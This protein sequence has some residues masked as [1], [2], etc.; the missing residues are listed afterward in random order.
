MQGTNSNIL[1]L[2]P[3]E[4]Y[5]AEDYREKVSGPNKEERVDIVER[6]YDK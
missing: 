3:S 5:F 6:H 1:S 2:R 4:Y